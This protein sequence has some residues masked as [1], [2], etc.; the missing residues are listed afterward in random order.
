VTELS[1][2]SATRLTEIREA[3]FSECRSMKAFT[4]HWKRFGLRL[5]VRTPLLRVICFCQRTGPRL[6]DTSGET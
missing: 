6:R 1:F 3:A 5:E 4:L 2:E